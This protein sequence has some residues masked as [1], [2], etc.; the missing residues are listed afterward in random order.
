MLLRQPAARAL[1]HRPA[2]DADAAAAEDPYV[3]AEAEPRDCRAFDSCLWEVDTLRSHF[4]PSVSSLAA[5]FARPFTQSTPPVELAPLAALS[6][7]SLIRVETQRKLKRAP[8]ATA[9]AEPPPR[10][11]KLWV[12]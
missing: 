3:A 12:P 5:L 7:D 10:H 11:A 2:A 9:P 1:I 8:I 6:A 4:C